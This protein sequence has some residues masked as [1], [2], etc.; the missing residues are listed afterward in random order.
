MILQGAA[1][2]GIPV[3][4]FG[5]AS[6]SA[7]LFSLMLPETLNKKLPESVAEVERTGRRKKGKWVLHILIN[8]YT[9]TFDFLKNYMLVLF[10]Q[11]PGHA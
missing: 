3:V 7:G 11:S 9:N 10:L 2:A 8:Y 5:I 1:H 4:I 6:A